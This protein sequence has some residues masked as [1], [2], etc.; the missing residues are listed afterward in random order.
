[1]EDNINPRR[2]TG[3]SRVIML[4]KVIKVVLMSY[5]HRNSKYVFDFDTC[6]RNVPTCLSTY[7]LRVITLRDVSTISVVTSP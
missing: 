7:G 4:V 6:S 2:M 3:S 5:F 1:M